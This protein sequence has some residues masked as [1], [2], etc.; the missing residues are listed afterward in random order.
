VDFVNERGIISFWPVKGLSLP[1]LWA[2]V[3]GNRPVP[4][5]HDDPGHITWDW[6]D[7]MLGEKCWYYSKLL[8][9]SGMF[10]SNELAPYF[11]ALT[12]NYG[13]LEDDYLILYEQGLL[14]QNA[15]QIYEALLEHGPVD[16]IALRRY[17]CFTHSGS[18]SSFN[19]ALN[20]L[21]ADMK[22]MPVGISDAGAWHYAYIYDIPARYLSELP[23]I[24]RNIPPQEARRTILESLFRSY[25][26]IEFSELVRLLHWRMDDLQKS[27]T[28]LEKTGRITSSVELEGKPGNWMA[29]INFLSK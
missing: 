14:S 17:A 27:L 18:D 29:S 28:S 7:R 10:V 5:W 21:Q 1:S 13:S 24:A 23:E 8:R 12:E 2:A 20:Q 3:V 19:T 11:Y 6:K 25:G 4:S 9:H 26:V 15:K 22:V 16:T